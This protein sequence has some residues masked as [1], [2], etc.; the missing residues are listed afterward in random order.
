[1]KKYFL[2]ALVLSTSMN[3]PANAQGKNRLGLP[4]T[5]MDS[6]VRQAGGNADLIYGDEGV[7]DIPPYD[8]FDPIHRIN[9]GIYDTRR[10]GLTT[11]HGS[12]LPD[13]WG[14]DEFTGNEWSQ[15]GAGR[16]NP[17]QTPVY[18]QDQPRQGGDPASNDPTKNPT[19][20]PA[21]RRGRGDLQNGQG[22]NGR[23]GTVI[24]SPGM[25]NPRRFSGG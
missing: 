3:L 13:A 14:G 25:N 19:S 8:Y 12:Y 10:K 17:T 4:P 6:F 22:G 18:Q 5:S 23:D 2:L 9:A 7:V 11:G 20:Q 15:S 1:M 24:R 16:G 21:P